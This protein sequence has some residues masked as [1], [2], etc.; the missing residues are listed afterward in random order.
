MLG[1]VYGRYDSQWV[2]YPRFNRLSW[3]FATAL[4]SLVLT[5]VAFFTLLTFYLKVHSKKVKALLLERQKNVDGDDEVPEDDDKNIDD[6]IQ[7]LASS[8][9]S[10]IYS[11]PDYQLV[12][13]PRGGSEIVEDLGDL[14]MEV[15]GDI[16]PDV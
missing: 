5:T 4:V 10:R 15:A 2:P 6:E 8:S 1:F 12:N 3:G 9:A 13:N 7:K 14:G 11:Q 16:Y